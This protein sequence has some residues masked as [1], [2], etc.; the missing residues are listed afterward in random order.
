M[1]VTWLNHDD[2]HRGLAESVLARLLLDQGQADMAMD[3]YR[4][5]SNIWSKLI[6]FQQR[7][8]NMS[9]GKEYVQLHET[10]QQVIRNIWLYDRRSAVSAQLLAEETS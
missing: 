4:T 8:H 2:H 1:A 7:K 10:T 3:H 6:D 9:K 5:A